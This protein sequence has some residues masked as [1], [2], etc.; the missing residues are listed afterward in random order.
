MAVYILP[1]MCLYIYMVIQRNEENNVS[2]K[3][4][5]LPHTSVKG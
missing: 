3:K 2:I 5:A 4:V 1:Y